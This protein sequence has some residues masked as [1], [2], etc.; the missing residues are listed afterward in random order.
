MSKMVYVWIGFNKIYRSRVIYSDKILFTMF[1]YVKCL[2]INSDCYFRFLSALPVKI[3]KIAMSFYSSLAY[4]RPI[5]YRY[6]LFLMI[7]NML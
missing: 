2:M 3:F 7:G 5:F 4:M 1:I 6:V